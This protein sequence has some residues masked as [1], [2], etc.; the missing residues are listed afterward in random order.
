MV[1]TADDIALIHQALMKKCNEKY[2][3]FSR[4][5]LCPVTFVTKQGI[6][7]LQD[8]PILLKLNYNW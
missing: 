3:E 7:L 1:K 8:C 5:Q 4:R 6:I 2:N